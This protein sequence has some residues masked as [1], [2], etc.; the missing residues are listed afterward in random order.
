[1]QGI[2]FVQHTPGVGEGTAGA[3][4]WRLAVMRVSRRKAGAGASCFASGLVVGADTMVELNGGVLEKPSGPREAARY[5]RMLSGN[6]HRVLSG[7][8]VWDARTGKRL[9]AVSCTHVFFRKMSP[10]DVEEYVTSGEWKDKAGG[11]AVQG[12]GARYV[13]RIEGSYYSVMGL[14]VEELFRLL[15]RFCYF[16][17]PA[18]GRY[19]PVRREL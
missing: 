8:T 15:E 1:M 5:L 2:P 7:I 9:S 12:K 6:R 13:R 11:Y 3:R 19:A 17:A 14:P 10:G 4:S 16:T 18:D